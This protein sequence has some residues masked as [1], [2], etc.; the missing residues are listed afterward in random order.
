MHYTMLFLWYLLMLFLKCCY[1]YN[2]TVQKFEV[3][4]YFYFFKKL[5][6]IFSKDVL[7]WSK[8]TKDIMLHNISMLYKCC[9]FELSIHLRI[10]ETKKRTYQHFHK[11]IKQ[12]ITVF[13]IDKIRNVSWAP[14]QHIRMIS[15]GSCDTECWRNGRWKFSFRNWKWFYIYLLFYNYCILAFHKYYCFT[16]FLFYCFKYI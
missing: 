10:L 13:D 6:L 15:E 1:I 4:I 2:Y 3:S 16:L 8:M 7:N 11:N 14:N 9:S 12:Y 5:M